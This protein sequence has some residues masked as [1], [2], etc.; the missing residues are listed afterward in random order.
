VGTS[1][2]EP[3]GLDERT[4][5]LYGYWHVILPGSKRGIRANRMFGDTDVRL[6]QTDERWT[7]DGFGGGGGSRR[8]LDPLKS[9]TL[10]LDGVFFSGTAALRVR[11]LSELWTA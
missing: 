5:K 6:P 10:V 11:I 2:L 4:R 9:V 1:L 3:F 7:G 8:P